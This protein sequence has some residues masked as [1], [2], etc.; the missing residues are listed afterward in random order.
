MNKQCPYCQSI[1]NETDQICPNCH[2]D[3]S[4]EC[5]YCKEIIK[6]Y[7]EVCPKCSTQLRKKDYSKMLVTVAAALNILWIL[8]NIAALALFA[9]IPQLSKLPDDNSFELVLRL[10]QASLGT[11]IAVTIPYIIAIVKNYKRAISIG[12]ITAN[13]V[14]MIIF[15]ICIVCLYAVNS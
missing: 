10:G 6:A 12:C 3:L 2:N 15:M 1:I 5:P 13:V 9:A 8:G 11:L 14:L 4:V 7:D